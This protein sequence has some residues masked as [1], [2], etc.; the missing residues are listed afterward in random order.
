MTRVRTLALTITFLLVSSMAMSV[1]STK[2]KPAP[3]PPSPSGTPDL[4][5]VFLDTR[6]HP[7]NGNRIR[8]KQGDDLQVAINQA[9]R[10][11]ILVLDAG[12]TFIGNFE[13]PKKPGSGW[14]VITTD[15]ELPPQGTRVTPVTASNFASL[16]SPNAQPAVLIPARASHYRTMGVEISTRS[17]RIGAILKVGDS[18]QVTL[19]DVPQHIVFDRVYVHGSPNTHARR[20]IQLNAANA[21]VVDSYVSEC[22]AKGADAQAILSWNTPGPLKIVN[23]YLE[24]SGENLMLGGAD[25]KILNVVPEDVEIRRNHFYKP[26]SWKNGRWSVKNLL[27]FKIGRRVLVEGNVFESNWAAAQAGFA[28]VIKSANQSGT[29][30]WSVTEHVTL[31]NNIIRDSSQGISLFVGKKSAPSL[32]A[33]SILISHNLMERIGSAS[34]HGGTGSILQIVGGVD[35]VTVEHNTFFGN[36]LTGFTGDKGKVDNFVFRNNIVSGGRYGLT[37]DGKQE[38][39]AT[40][41][42]FATGGWVMEGNVVIGR[43]AR[44]YPANNYFPVDVTAVGFQDYATGI[45]RLA[46]SSPYK[47]V[48]SGI[49]PGVAIA[50]VLAATAGVK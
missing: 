24:G 6:Y 49:D 22:H 42:G 7:P 33:N 21:A 44:Y 11:E 47:G 8:V 1:P 45:Y 19:T 41:N 2:V 12:A 26:P 5:R 17:P 31:R 32:P 18:T 40:L 3:P 25:P 4:P 13:L 50:R 28:I 16:E 48:L 43:K 14:I 23:N 46:D 27:E 38:G 39:L 29:A 34:S 20:G 30:P 15:T 35:G 9:R 10:G 36:R 37:G